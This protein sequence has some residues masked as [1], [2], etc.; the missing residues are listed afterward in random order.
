MNRLSRTAAALAALALTAPLAACGTVDESL[1]DDDIAPFDVS[2]ITRDD[3]IAAMLPDAVAGDGVLSVGMNPTYAPAE[4]LAADGVTPVGY[5]VD[6]ARALARVMGLEATMVIANFDSIIPSIGSKFDLG[7]T[8]FT[9]TPERMDAVDFISYY[10][11]G[12]TWVTQTGNPRQVDTADL[13][14]VKVAV[15]TGTM[16]ESQI[17]DMS[18]QCRDEGRR[19]IELLPSKQQ[20]DATT[21][22]ATGRAAVFYADSPVAGYAIARTGGLLEPLGE[23]EGAAL[24][25]IAVAKGDTATAQAVQAALQRLIDDGTYMALL[26]HWGVES[27]AVD[28]ARIN[29]DDLS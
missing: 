11:A 25:G 9:I 28:A 14:G 10:R 21:Y 13:C 6:L 19:A 20:T 18:E 29:P 12:S 3:A 17:M 5:D 26:E 24:Q 2:A 22:V 16:Q 23:D 1:G 4:F 27:G 8:S 15:Q 7:I